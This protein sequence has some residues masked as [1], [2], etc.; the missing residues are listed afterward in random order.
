MTLAH[1]RGPLT[2]LL[3][4]TALAACGPTAASTAS[5]PVA[6]TARTFDATPRLIPQPETLHIIGGA[7]FVLDS[8]TTIVTDGGDAAGRIGD[9]LAAILRPSTDFAVRFR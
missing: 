5:T 9:A 1:R 7:P 2:A 6:R 8:A 3:A 4:A